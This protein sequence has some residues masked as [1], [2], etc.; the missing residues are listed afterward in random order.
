MQLN[1]HSLISFVKGAI[2][3]SHEDGWT[4]FYRFTEAQ[5]DYYFEKT[6][7]T[8]Y[9]KTRATAGMKLDIITDA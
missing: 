8:L 9:P 3:T 1:D 6:P 5:S 4:S 2:Y 7:D